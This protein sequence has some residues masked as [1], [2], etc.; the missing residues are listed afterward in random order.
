MIRDQVASLVKQALQAVDIDDTPHLTH[1]AN[2]DFGDYA[3]NVALKHAKRLGKNPVDLAQEVASKIVDSLLISKVEVAKPGFINIYLSKKKLLEE[4]TCINELKENYGKGKEKDRSV[5]VEFSSPNIAKPFTIGHLRSTIIG[6]SLSKILEFYGYTVFKDNHVGDWGTQFG[7]LIYEIQEQ[8]DGDLEKTFQEIG[9][10]DRP[11]K[12]L[13]ELYINFHKK[14][15]QNPA[16]DDIAREE[17]RQL[18]LGHSLQRTIWEKCIEWSWKEF[19]H[20]YQLLNI[21]F[22]ENDGHGYGESQFVADGFV[23]NE[24]S[25]KLDYRESEGAKLVFFKDDRLPPLMIQKKDGSS[26]YATRDLGTDFFRKKNEERYGKDPI[27]INEVGIEQSLYFQQLYEI[28]YELGWFKQGERIHV[29]HGHYRFKDKKMSTRKGDVIWLEDVLEEAENRAFKLS[30]RD[31]FLNDT[32]GE[33]KN[34]TKTS[35][36]HQKRIGQIMNDQA[37]I[38]YSAIKWNDLKRDSKLDIV[39]DW[40]EIL[41]MEGDSGPYMLYTYVRALNVLK[42]ANRNVPGVGFEPNNIKTTSYED[43]LLRLLYQFPEVVESAATSYSPHII[44]HYAY[45]LAQAF[46]SF[47]GNCK[48]LTGNKNE[49]DIRLAL[50]K[51]VSTQIATSLRLLGIQTVAS[52]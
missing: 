45:S 24:I 36:Q 41:N 26:L 11:V 5:I 33:L 47:Y 6:D 22:T 8:N 35:K 25:K 37:L 40:D 39:F 46:N 3:T 44:A 9:N 30:G 15:E 14:A 43:R 51:A 29:K 38:A 23:L 13:V 4:L 31:V 49:E 50:T 34:T 16:L 1:P 17:F 48:I 42:L 20:I 28:E 18:E 10:M 52:M 21:S 7:K 32:Y 2:P 12:K 27:V 19:D